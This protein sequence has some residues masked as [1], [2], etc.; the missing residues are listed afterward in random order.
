MY[1]RTHIDTYS[2]KKRSMAESERAREERLY[3][4]MGNV[5]SG[6]RIESELKSF[7]YLCLVVVASLKMATREPFS[8]S[9]QDFHFGESSE[10][11]I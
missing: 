10:T 4:R 3:G 11:L 6:S 2:R 9:Y 7:T 1:L 5:P 8:E